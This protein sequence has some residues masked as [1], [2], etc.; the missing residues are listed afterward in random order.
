M[1]FP[2]SVRL[3]GLL[4]LA[5]SLSVLFI[6]RNQPRGIPPPARSDTL[7]A[8]LPPPTV[9]PTPTPSPQSIRDGVVSPYEISRYLKEHRDDP[10]FS[11]AGFWQDLGIEKGDVFW[12]G[13]EVDFFRLPLD[14]EAGNEVILRLFSPGLCRYLIFK[15]MVKQGRRSWRFLGVIDKWQHMQ[16]S[17]HRLI[18]TKSQRWLV[19]TY[20]AGRGSGYGR[21]CQDWYV[22][23]S[24]GIKKA[25]S[26]TS[27][28]YFS[29]WGSGLETK[30]DSAI[31]NV[32]EKAGLATVS[33]RFTISYSTSIWENHQDKSIK[34]W[35]KNRLVSFQQVASSKEFVFDQAHSQLSQREIDALYDGLFTACE[36]VLQYNY[37]DLVRVAKNKPLVAKSWLKKYLTVCSDSPHQRS[38]LRRLRHVPL[39]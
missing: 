20:E 8:T 7:P 2:L 19:I 29:G 26:Y 36:D 34:L 18:A 5:I 30:S 12:Q 9:T 11:M 23:T 39:P 15:P 35:H 38:L 16:P 4:L 17:E 31:I 13:C 21:G 10:E 3:L 32:K 14:S 6:A 22:V 33:L 24:N 28:K 25:L 27:D 37:S 1:D